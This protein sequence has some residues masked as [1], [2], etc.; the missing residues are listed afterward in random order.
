MSSTKNVWPATVVALGFLGVVGLVLWQALPDSST[1]DDFL[2]VWAGVGT[3]VGVVTGAIPSFFFK[4]QAEGAT[5]RA[6]AAQDVARASEQA[7][8]EAVEEKREADEKARTL[9]HATEDLLD[10]M[11][12]SRSQVATAGLNDPFSGLEGQIAVVRNR[13]RNITTP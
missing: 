1:V 9:A 4:T 12:A 6:A 13:I 10:A 7:A 3:L 11:K 2:K 5:Q 8:R